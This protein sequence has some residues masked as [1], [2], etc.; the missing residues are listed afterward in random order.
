MNQHFDQCAAA[1]CE[2]RLAQGGRESADFFAARLRRNG[3]FMFESLSDR[4]SGV[5]RT[6]SGR[7]QLTEENVQ[8]GLRE[9]RLAL[10]EADVNFKVVKD[11]VESVREKC[12]GQEVLKGVS[13]AQ[14]VI[15]IVNDELVQLLGGETAGLN[16]QGRE[17]AVIML[18][19]LQ[20]S[21]K[22]TSAGKIAN[23]LRK[24]KLRPYLVPADVYRPAAIDQLTVLAKQLDMPCFP[25]TVDM[26]PVDIAKAALEKAREE[27]ATVLLIDTAGR[28]HVDGD[29]MAEL[30]RIKENV[31]VDETLLVIDAM[32]GQDAVNVAK[33]FSESTGLDGV[34]LTKLDGD[35]R[36]GSALSV[37]AVTGKPIKFAGVGEKLDDLEVFH[38]S[39]MA[40]RIL[41]MGDVLTLIE[42]A[43]DT[44]DQ[45]KAEET[46]KRLMQNKFDMNDMLDQFEQVK[47]M[48][49]AAAMMSMFPGAGRISDDELDKSEKELGRMK[50]I[51]QSMTKGE[52]A[53]PSI[54]DPKRKRRI[55]AG[56]G[57]RVEDVN[58]LLRQYE[59]MQKM[60]KQFK[61]NP[62]GFGRGMKGLGG[63][64][65]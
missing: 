54:I 33:S 40:S 31:Q 23:I 6:F 10:L 8:A 15:K 62:K 52:R 48:G 30:Q 38:P 55:A 28:L 60:M 42:K 45:K 18:V 59:Q 57:T 50:A 44:A 7:G 14:Q 49:G 16:L 24:Q 61:K 20:G 58:R 25:S 35:T 19:G 27:Q 22:T 43:Q 21:G 37:R 64:F 46:A 47:K 17:P 1:L 12:L 41:G 32:A 13:P 51:I 29:L 34:I 36:G 3:D 53:K 4:L 65:R 9:V 5:F 2:Q 63:M 26:N 11:F 56:S 39:R